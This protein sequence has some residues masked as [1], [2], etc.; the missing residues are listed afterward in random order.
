MMTGPRRPSSGGRKA[1]RLGAPASDWLEAFPIGNGR[2]GAM[3]FGRPAAERI[4]VNEDTIWAGGPYRN[5]NPKALEHLAEVRGLLNGGR[6]REAQKIADEYWVLG[7]RQGM[8]YQLAGSLGIAFDGIGQEEGYSRELDLARGVASVEFMAS[9]S[10]HRRIAF[11][12]LC[13]PAIILRFETEAPGALNFSLRW[14][15]PMPTLPG[16]ALGADLVLRGHGTDHE[17]VP[18]LVRFEARARVIECDGTVRRGEAGDLDVAGASRATVAIAVATSFVD[19]ANVT[20]DPAARVLAQLATLEKADFAALLQSHTAAFESWADRADIDLGSGLRDGMDIDERV[21][22]FPDGRDPELASLF[23]RYG[24]YLLISSSQPGSQAATLQGIWNEEPEPPWDSKYTT[25]IN[26]EMN[27]WPSLNTDLLELQEPLLRLVREVS[28]TGRETARSMYGARGWALHHN[29]DIWRITGPVDRMDPS[30]WAIWPTCGAWLCQHLWFSYAYSGETSRLAEAWPIIRGAC[31]FF[32]DFLAEKPGTP[33]LV[34]SPSLSPENGHHEGCSIADGVTMDNSMLRELFATALETMRLLGTKDEIAERISAAAGRLPPFKIGK[35]GQLQEWFEDWDRPEDRHRHISHL[36][37]LYP[38]N[39]ISA[40][41]T[42]ELALAARTSLA[43]R[44]D[45]STGW[46]TG[47]KVNCWARLFDGDRAWKIFKES[48]H[49]ANRSTAYNEDGGV[50][51]N[52]LSAHAPFQIDGNFGSTAGLAELLLQS[53]DGEI[54]LLPALPSEWREGRARGLSA[55]GGFVVDI[56][57]MAG[58]LAAASVRSR[59]GGNLRIRSAAALALADGS[60]PLPASGINSNP[61]FFV[62][63]ID[64]QGPQ[65][66]APGFVYDIPTEPGQTVGFHPA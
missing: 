63:P 65:A 50:Y 22:L 29:T 32:L 4:Q 26:L 16:E 24:R 44:G 39:Q 2:L 42:P 66:A 5:D 15:T 8:P 55:R 58:R 62:T 31:E 53:H 45:L 47:W 11:A 13:H 35:W 3:V 46:S 14:S 59:R 10:R 57:W 30:Y 28:E 7:D 51:P 27:Y 21:R 25:N 54:D 17:G 1:L 43:A 34:I 36:W 52:F 40:R 61:C 60:H 37:G 9:G 41:R 20:A 38:S 56:E 18:G 6:W 49:P 23:F 12:S 64:G 33:Y 19:Y 48:I